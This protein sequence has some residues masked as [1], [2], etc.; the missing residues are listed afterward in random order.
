MLRALAS[1][2]QFLPPGLEPPLISQDTA[3]KCPDVF[4]LPPPQVHRH[5][6]GPSPLRDF[7]LL[8][9]SPDPHS[10]LTESNH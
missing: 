3:T 7:L 8:M 4:P 6:R 1:P 9:S 2:D 10:Y 5:H